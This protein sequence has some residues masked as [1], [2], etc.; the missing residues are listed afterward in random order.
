[1][2]GGPEI[3]IGPRVSPDGHMVTFQAM[4]QGLTQVAVMT[5]E[6]GNWVVLTHRNATS[7]R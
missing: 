1:M 4:V 7:A 6:S 3:A 5:P 2:L